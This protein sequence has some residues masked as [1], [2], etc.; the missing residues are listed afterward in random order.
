MG[1]ARTGRPFD[2]L[3]AGSRDSRRDASAPLRPAAGLTVEC[4]LQAY[5]E[6]LPQGIVP[7]DFAIQQSLAALAV[8]RLNQFQI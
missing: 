7:F 3:R 6:Q 1:V 8:G 4:I 5:S 2:G